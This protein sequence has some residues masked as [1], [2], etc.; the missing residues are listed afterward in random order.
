[1]KRE[2]RFRQQEEQT[3]ETV[4]A[5]KQEQVKEFASVEEMLTH[6]SSQ[7]APPAIIEERLK[8]S[9]RNEPKPERSWWQRVFKSE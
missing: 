6:D 5:A 4:R 3:S 9:I 7:V 2:S 8:R 1:M